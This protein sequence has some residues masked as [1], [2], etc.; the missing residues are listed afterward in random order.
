MEVSWPANT[1][2]AVIVFSKTFCPYSKKAKHILLDIYNIT[3]APY[4][5]ELDVHPLGAQLQAALARM[6]KRRTVPNVLINGVSIGGGDDVEEL[7]VSGKLENTIRSMSGKRVTE[8]KL[9]E[10]AEDEQVEMRRERSR[11]IRRRGRV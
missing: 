9:M 5:V 11:E 4:V 1:T 8:I 6:T 3:P 2:F 10:G 7:H